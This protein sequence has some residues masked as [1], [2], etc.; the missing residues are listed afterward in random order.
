[1]ALGAGSHPHGGGEGAGGGGGDA[2]DDR[3]AVRLLVD[4][5]WWRWCWWDWLEASFSCASATDFF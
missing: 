1:V 2:D 3:A 4:F 5:A